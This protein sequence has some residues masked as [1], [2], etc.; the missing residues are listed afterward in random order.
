MTPLDNTD[1]RN[2]W[3]AL[4]QIGAFLCFLLGALYSFVTW[5]L[6]FPK[7]YVSRWQAVVLILYALLAFVPVSVFVH[8]GW[9]RRSKP[10]FW[11]VAPVEVLVLG[12]FLCTILTE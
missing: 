3:K 4:L 5:K 2:D 8:P 10:T 9:K 11:G 12:L 1:G 6:L 7:P